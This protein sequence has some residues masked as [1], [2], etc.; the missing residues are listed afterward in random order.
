[1]KGAAPGAALDSGGDD[2]YLRLA[3]DRRSLSAAVDW[4]RFERLP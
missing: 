4:L 2:A 3:P 1:V